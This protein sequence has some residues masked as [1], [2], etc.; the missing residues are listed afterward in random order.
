MSFASRRRPHRLDRRLDDRGRIDRLD[1]EPQ[2]AGDDAAHV[3]QVLDELGLDARVPL[4][5]LEP[6]LDVCAAVTRR[7]R[8]ICDQPRIAFSG[9]R[10]S[11]DSVARNSS[12]IAL[13]RSASARRD[14]LALER[15]AGALPAARPLVGDVAEGPHPP[16]G[17]AVDHL[18]FEK[19][20]NTRPSPSSS[21][22]WLSGGAVAWISGDSLV[23]PRR[24]RT[25]G[26]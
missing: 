19:P 13:A 3:E 9:V 2:L 8:R 12:F 21:T 15:A 10:S 6:L 20:S 26:R 25:P 4:D 17:A 11:W 23:N 22:P 1:V 18:E 7:L 24:R 14:P 5:D 16:R